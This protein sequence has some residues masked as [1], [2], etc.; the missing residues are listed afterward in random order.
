MARGNYKTQPQGLGFR[1]IVNSGG[2]SL[3]GGGVAFY[4]GEK[5]SSQAADGHIFSAKAPCSQQAKTEDKQ[6][7][8]G[9]LCLGSRVWGLGFSLGTAPSVTIG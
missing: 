2:H 5:I 4:Q 6:H 3:W 8:I 7:E 9:G 1:A